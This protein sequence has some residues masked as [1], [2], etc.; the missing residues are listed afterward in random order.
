MEYQDPKPENK[1]HIGSSKDRSSDVQENLKLAS[2]LTCS[3]VTS[4]AS[5]PRSTGGDSMM[6]ESDKWLRQERASSSVQAELLDTQDV[7]EVTH[8]EV[9]DLCCQVELLQSILQEEEHQLH[10]RDIE[11]QS[12][13]AEV[14]CSQRETREVKAA[15]QSAREELATHWLQGRVGIDGLEQA[16]TNRESSRDRFSEDQNRNRA[17]G[18]LEQA[19]VQIA[20]LQG[21]LKRLK[22]TSHDQESNAP[23]C[24]RWSEGLKVHSA[25]QRA[26]QHSSSSKPQSFE[27]SPY[28]SQLAKMTPEHIQSSNESPPS[29]RAH[30][31]SKEKRL[32]QLAIRKEHDVALAEQCWREK[33]AQLEHQLAEMEDG[34]RREVLDLQEKI[35]AL[36]NVNGENATGK[37][38]ILVVWYIYY[39]LH[40]YHKCHSRGTK[41][42]YTLLIVHS[43]IHIMCLLLWVGG[44]P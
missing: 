25:T 23:L 31:K 29:R 37:L 5:A 27:S 9:L 18:E 26:A 14:R 10:A 32:S 17:A 36:Q 24:T 2:T 30:L 3:A 35:I 13:R 11:L 42:D 16:L 7:L 40:V 6:V 8:G 43:T 28:P 44:L 19:R 41:E 34:R 38:S 20:H 1:V 33:V 22:Q 4:N 21:E 39:M 15:L 12:L